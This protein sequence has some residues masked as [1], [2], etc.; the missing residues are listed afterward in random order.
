MISTNNTVMLRLRLTL[1]CGGGGRLPKVVMIAWATNPFS[2]VVFNYIC[3]V[4]PMLTRF[5][6]LTTMAAFALAGYRSQDT[7]R[8]LGTGSTSSWRKLATRGHAKNRSR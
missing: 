3:K 4:V 5:D 1:T 6:G 8:K 2:W 7:R